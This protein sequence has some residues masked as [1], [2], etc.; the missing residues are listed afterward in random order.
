MLEFNTADIDGSI[1]FLL[2]GLK[3]AFVTSLLGILASIILKVLATI[4]ISKTVQEAK[5]QDVGIEDLYDIMNKQNENLVLLNNKLSDNDDSSL[6]G[7]IKLMRSDTTDNHKVMVKSLEPLSVLPDMNEKLLGSTQQLQSMYILL[8]KQH[9][10]FN[11]FKET[12]WIKLQDFAD[13][14]SKSATEQV[15]NALKEVV[16]DFN[17]KLGEQFADNFEKLHVAVENLVLW[18]DQYKVQLSDMKDQFDVSVSSMVEMEKSVESISTHSKAIPESMKN[19][20]TVITTNQHQVD[21]LSNHLE[22]FKEV[23]E[24]AVQAVPEIK[25]Q[26]EKTIKGFQEASTELMT[27]VS[28]STEKVSQILVQNAEDFSENVSQTNKALVDS[29]DTLKVTSTEMRD[30]LEVMLLDMNKQ[31]KLMIG[32]LTTNSKEVSL[33]FKEIG[34]SLMS[35]LSSTHEQVQTK[36]I[37]TTENLQSSIDASTNEQVKQMQNSFGVLES[38]HKQLNT[39]MEQIINDFEVNIEKVSQ[40]QVKQVHKVFDSVEHTIDQAL[41]KTGDSVQNQVTLMDKVAGQEIENIMNAMGTALT[42]IT[43]QFTD[44]YQKLVV[45][46]KRVVESRG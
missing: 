40:E 6:I 17:N 37:Q 30:L 7:Q 16:Q 15:I 3:V 38:G 46:M 36:I 42:T 8:E 27:G 43:K 19:L 22:A 24:S 33:E 2:E 29:S 23:R 25:S 31:I 34:S 4:G 20:Q 21:E 39:S 5:E 12:L 26:I 35:E 44:D 45:E 9:E 32:E 13:M 11:S 10:S 28:Q 41:Q 1:T 18:Q 14:L